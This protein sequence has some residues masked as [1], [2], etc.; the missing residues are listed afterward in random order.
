[1]TCSSLVNRP[2]AALRPG[3]YAEQGAQYKGAGSINGAGSY[4]FLLTASDGSPDRLR[5]Q[6]WEVATA[7]LVYD[8][9][10]NA[11][12]TADPV[13]ALGGGSIIIQKG[14]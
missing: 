4:A 12:D 11:G 8:N 6:I 2:R 10:R 5:I 3:Q 1:M 7:E 13:T 14:K 9:Q